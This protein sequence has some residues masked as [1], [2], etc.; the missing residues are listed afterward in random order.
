MSLNKLALF[1]AS[2]GGIYDKIYGCDYV[3]KKY[4]D[5]KNTQHTDIKPTP[6]ECSN[7]IMLSLNKRLI[8]C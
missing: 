5:I 2:T 4:Q 8:I 1:F 6:N 7:T 3:K